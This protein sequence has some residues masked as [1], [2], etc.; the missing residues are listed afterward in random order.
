MTDFTEAD[1][2]YMKE[3]IKEAENAA[4]VGEVPIGAVVVCE[5]KIIGRGSNRKNMGK[6]ALKHAEIIAIEDASSVIGD[7]RLDEC[8]LYV[9][10]EPCLMCSGAIIHAR[11][12]NVIFGTTEPK[13]GGV[14]SLAKTF[15]IERLNHKVNYKGGLYA[16]EIASM[17]KSFF[18]KLRKP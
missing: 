16:E 17:M 4:E 14:V 11:V 2:L 7:W 10:L 18:K 9:T 5:G 3:A 12:R 1:K 15:D 6:S 8:S 13:F